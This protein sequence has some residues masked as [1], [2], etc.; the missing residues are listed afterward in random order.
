MSEQEILQ[1]IIA[2]FRT[3]TDAEEI[4]ESSELI[5]DLGVSSMDVLFLV[6]NLEEE[7]GIKI[8][9]RHIRRMTTIADVA[10]VVE[11]LL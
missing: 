7:F 8:S 5:E 1:R 10:Q 6:S 11:E 4:T 9:E 3:M 2:L